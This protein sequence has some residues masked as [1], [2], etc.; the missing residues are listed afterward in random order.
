MQTDLKQVI[1]SGP[2]FGTVSSLDDLGGKQVCVNPLSVNYQNL[3]QVNARLKQSG[4]PLIVI[5]AAD[6]DLLDDDLLQMVNAELLPAT[7]TKSAREAVVADPAESHAASR[8]GDRQRRAS[9][10]GRAQG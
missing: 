9:G 8:L 7:V 4:K 1:V 3:Q 6:K 10:M 5:K 2:N